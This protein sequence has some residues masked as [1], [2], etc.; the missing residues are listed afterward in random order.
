MQNPQNGSEHKYVPRLSTLRRPALSIHEFY[1][2][3]RS[4]FDH[5]SALMLEHETQKLGM[6]RVRYQKQ[7]LELWICNDGVHRDH[8]FGWPPFKSFVA[9][10]S[11]PRIS[12]CCLQTR[13][14]LNCATPQATR[15]RLQPER[16]NP[17][18]PRE[19]L[20]A[21]EILAVPRDKWSAI[22]G[23]RLLASLLIDTKAKLMMHHLHHVDRPHC[24]ASPMPSP[25]VLGSSLLESMLSGAKAKLTMHQMHHV[26]RPP[27]CMSLVL[28]RT[29]W[30]CRS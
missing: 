24:C 12:E 7:K 15:R 8:R 21:L 14:F 16:R 9:V 5:T 4:I 23:S 2:P 26:E 1:C 19:P 30:A 22:L 6:P 3:H 20:L 27:C 29:F 28:R 17:C 10:L 13:S 18:G 11:I 25:N